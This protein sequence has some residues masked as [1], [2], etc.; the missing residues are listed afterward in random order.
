MG[1]AIRVGKLME[2]ALKHS[3]EPGAIRFEGYMEEFKRAY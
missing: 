3:P 1:A 2:E